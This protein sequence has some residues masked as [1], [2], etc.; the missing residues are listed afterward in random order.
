MTAV[1]LAR[2]ATGR[3]KI[4]KFAGHYHGHVDGLLAEA[5]S[6]PRD[7]GHPGLARASRRR[8]PPTRSS[9]RGTTPT[10]SRRRSDASATAR[11]G[12]GRAD[13]GEHGAGARARRDSCELLREPATPR[14]ALLVLDEVITGFR[15]ARGGAQEL[16]GVR[17]DLTIL[18][19]VLG[20]GLPLAAVAGPRGADGAAR[21]G[22]RDLPGRHAVGQPARDRRRPGDAARARRRRLR[23]AGRARPSALPR[24]A[25][26]GAAPAST[27]QVA[28]ETGLLTVFFSRA[29]GDATTTARRRPTTRPSRASSDA[30]LERGIYL[31]PS[32]YEAWFPSLAHT[33]EQIDR[34]IEAAAEAFEAVARLSG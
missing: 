21:A 31:P 2:A 33:D 26:S 32:P 23:A 6:G 9:F 24:A 15:V 4:V 18:G 20:G 3:D 27:V 5:G 13:A 29:A 14:G 12:H 34:T 22:R 25:R 10:R 7:A 17:P 1:R 16:L 28:S 8:R 30:M 11:R 19:K